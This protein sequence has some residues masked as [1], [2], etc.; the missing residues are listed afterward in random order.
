VTDRA[1]STVLDVCLCLLL[2]SA[3][4]LTLLAAPVDGED[5]AAGTADELA[6]TLAAGT[7]TVRYGGPAGTR[8]AHGTYAGLLATAARTNRTPE[9]GG[10]FRAAVRSTIRG[11]LDGDDWHARVRATWRP[12]EAADPTAVVV[13]PSPP[14]GADV[15]AAVTSAPSGLQ[16]VG[17]EARRAAARSDYRGVAVVLVETAVPGADERRRRA[18]VRRTTA[19]LR[20]RYESPLAAARA[21]TVGRVRVTVR[22]WSP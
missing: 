7:T 21:V 3:S 4:V 20:R 16:P 18:Y 17:P 15:H 1:V 11:V 6:T 10:R 9:T 22:T 14:P 2:V 5:P 12:Y 19:D 8:A 13:G